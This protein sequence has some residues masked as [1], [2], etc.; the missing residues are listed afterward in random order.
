M[1]LV[2]RYVNI[3]FGIA[4]IIKPILATLMMGICMVFIYQQLLCIFSE[5]LCI[6]LTLL[7]V[8]T[9]YFLLILVL[10]VF[11]EEEIKKIPFGSAVYNVL[12]VL[13][14]YK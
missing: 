7:I 1:H 14:I 5:K 8:I 10:K 13:K 11:S 6:L 12:K 9:I 2:K 4:D 3:K